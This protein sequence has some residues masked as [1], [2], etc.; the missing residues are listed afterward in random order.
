M[1]T[2]GFTVSFAT[3]QP[4]NTRLNNHA[5]LVKA[6]ALRSPRY[7]DPPVHHPFFVIDSLY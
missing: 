2:W 3:C 6:L 4:G 7:A 5:R 1:Q